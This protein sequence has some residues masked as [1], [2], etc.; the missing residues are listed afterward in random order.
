MIFL[1]KCC[2]TQADLDLLMLSQ[3]Y[4]RFE[5]KKALANSTPAIAYLPELGLSVSGRVTIPDG[6]AVARGKV[7]LFNKKS[8]FL[9]DTLSDSEG[10]FAFG[11]LVYTDSVRFLLQAKA[12][13]GSDKVVIKL[14]DEKLPAY[15]AFNSSSH[16]TTIFPEAYLRN[17]KQQSTQGNENGIVLQEVKVKAAMQHNTRGASAYSANL[18]GAGVA[19]QVLTSKDLENQGGDLSVI[20]MGKLTN[21]RVIN[22]VLVSSRSASLRGGRAMLIILDGNYFYGNL[23]DINPS[24]VES[25]EVLKSAGN[26]APYGSRGG[27]GVV[28]ITTKHGGDDEPQKSLNAAIVILPGFYKARVFYSPPYNSPKANASTPDKRST[29][30]WKPDIVTNKEGDASLSFF[31]AAEKGTYRVVIEGIG[32]NGKLGYQIFYYKAE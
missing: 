30:Y 2:R 4:R 32:I 1:L 27:N 12:T 15:E 28:I 31:N 25:I 17:G 23:S 5:W 26:T 3:G 16:D 9:L 14:D 13:D 7:T 29:I 10:R 22:G 18:N 24:D 8:N 20:L 21:I 19:D 6:R 11:N